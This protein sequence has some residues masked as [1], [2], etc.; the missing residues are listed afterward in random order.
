MA[1]FS[2]FDSYAYTL[3][4]SKFD[5]LINIIATLSFCSDIC[6]RSCEAAKLLS[7]VWIV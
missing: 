4:E 7:N 5:K 2:K 1:T 3:Q 6:L